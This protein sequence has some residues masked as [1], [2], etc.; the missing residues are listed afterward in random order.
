MVSFEKKELEAPKRVCLR[1]KECREAN[2][3]TLGELARRTRLSERYL[4]AIESCRFDAI[5]FGVVYQKNFIKRYA[6]A[7]SLPPEEFLKQFS[8]EEMT[9][10][11][12]GGVPATSIAR[13]T[14]LRNM[15]STIRR[16]ALG[17]GVAAVIMYLGFQVKQ[18]I[19]PPP[20]ALYSPQ[21]GAVVTAPEVAI[22]GA[23]TKEIRVF[24]NSEPVITDGNGEFKEKIYLSPGINTI[25]VSA[26][27]KHGKTTTETRHVIVKEPEELSYKTD[28][29]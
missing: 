18:S 10:A 26:K 2:G 6:A 25:V 29:I 20:L 4:V 28:S 9:D 14:E 19:E 8:A 13:R 16:L 17:T 7:L 12:P 1:L 11:P 5:P 23:T 15:P 27:R 3:I 21:N 22:H 24:I